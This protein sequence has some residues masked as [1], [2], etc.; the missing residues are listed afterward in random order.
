[1]GG[2][3]T[4]AMDK[5]RERLGSSLALLFV[6][7]YPYTWL[8]RWMRRPRIV[9]VSQPGPASSCPCHATFAD[10]R[11]RILCHPNSKLSS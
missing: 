1:M 9:A 6:A 4:Y 2:P 3:R 5:L 7:V 8:Q 10:A 11:D